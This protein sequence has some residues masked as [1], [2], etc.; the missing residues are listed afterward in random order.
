MQIRISIFCFTA[1]TIFQTY[2]VHVI[3]HT[4]AISIQQN[5]IDLY[6]FIYYPENMRFIIL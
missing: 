2:M 4:I 6:Y 1:S 5:L 3:V